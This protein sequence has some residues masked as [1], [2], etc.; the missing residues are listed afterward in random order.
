MLV[1]VALA[2]TVITGIV[3]TMASPV[4]SVASVAVTPAAGGSPTA[5]AELYVHVHG[6]VARPGIYRLATDARVIDVI[7]AAGGLTR[8]AEPSGINLARALT[9][10]EQVRVPARGEEPSTLSEGSTGVPPGS[11]AD[12]GAAPGDLVDLNTADGPTLETLP[13]IGPALAQRIIEW[14]EQNG[15]FSSVDDL[16]AVPGIGDKMLDALRDLVTT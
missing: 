7:A 10:G 6:Q 13:R 12:A 1:V 4:E 8:K 15:G 16:L 2:I 3:R 9:D 14:R 5:A 11:S